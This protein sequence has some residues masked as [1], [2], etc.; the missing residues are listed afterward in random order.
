MRILTL[1]TYYRPHTSGLTIYAE[2]LAKALVRRGHEVTVLTTQYEM[3]LPRDEMQ[4]GVRIVRLP[5]IARINK[6]VLAPSFGIVSTRLV[7]NHDVL[8]LHLPQLDAAGVAL[9]GRLLKKPTVI[10]YHCDLLLP[11]GLGN[12]IVNLVVDV[13]NNIAAVFTHKIT[14]YTEDFANHSPYLSRYAYKREVIPPPIALPKAPSDLVEAFRREHNPN[15]RSVI[16]M[17]TRFAAEKGVEILLDA[18]PKVLERVPDTMVFY[19]G[20][21]EGVWG[22]E[23]YATRLMPR[24][25]EYGA[26]GRWKFFGVLTLPQIAAF[27]PNLDV[28]VVPSLNS[29][30]TFGIVQ[31]EA[32]MN[33]IPVVASDL[34]GV[35]QPVRMTSMG[36]VIPIG[37][38]TALANAILSIFENPDRYRRDTEAITRKFL[39]DA[40]AKAYEALFEKLQRQMD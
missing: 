10:A 3:N 34:P 4:D 11:R 40:T 31:I 27:Y 25:A 33:G 9:R 14:A 17:V 13:M 38:S 7:L 28:L 16:G 12:R 5:V 20:Q 21:H 24:I 2:Q 26:E 8:L 29:T 18:L 15:G 23:A 6:G 37:D 35:R 39:P 1:L 19:A 36:K 22:E 30:E 32:M